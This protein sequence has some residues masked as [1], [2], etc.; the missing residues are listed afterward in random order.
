MIYRYLNCDLKIRFVVPPFFP[1]IVRSSSSSFFFFVRRTNQPLNCEETVCVIKFN[2]LSN[3]KIN[4]TK[5]RK[6]NSSCRLFLV[7]ETVVWE[8]E[9]ASSR[10]G[11]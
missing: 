9:K 10:S 6:T 7:V 3:N 11:K 4:K 1:F 2:S 5:H 8:E